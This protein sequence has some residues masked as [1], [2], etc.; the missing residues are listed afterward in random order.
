M[1]EYIFEL[2]MGKVFLS[3]ILKAKYMVIWKTIPM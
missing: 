1:G 3:K 2:E